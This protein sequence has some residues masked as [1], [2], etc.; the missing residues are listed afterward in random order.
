MIQLKKKLLSF[1]F[2]NCMFSL[3][4]E[5]GE[6]VGEWE[7]EELHQRV[8]NLLGNWEVRNLLNWLYFQEICDVV[9][10]F[11]F[12][13]VSCNQEKK[14]CTSVALSS[15][16]LSCCWQPPFPGTVVGGSGT[17]PKP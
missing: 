7:N 9:L 15:Y 4:S 6:F 11:G 12:S 13:T 1:T 10:C 17:I 5:A 3:A 14:G 16:T 2:G 8:N